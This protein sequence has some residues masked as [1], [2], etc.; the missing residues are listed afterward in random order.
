MAALKKG[1]EMLPICNEASDDVAAELKKQEEAIMQ[2]LS[3]AEASEDQFSQR[4]A[5]ASEQRE[6][7]SEEI[8]EAKAARTD[9]AHLESAL[10]TQRNGNAPLPP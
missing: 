1:A 9:Y 3:H 4:A 7:I 2:A 5:E 10:K 6:V 8:T